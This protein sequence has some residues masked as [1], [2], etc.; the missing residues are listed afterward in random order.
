MAHKDYPVPAS[1]GNG[2]SAPVRPVT[3]NPEAI[4]EAIIARAEGHSHDEQLNVARALGPL[5]FARSETLA[6]LVR[7]S[8]PAARPRSSAPSSP[9][10]L[11]PDTLAFLSALLDRIAPKLV[12]EFG[13]GESTRVFASWVADHDSRLISI[14][15]DKGWVAEVEQQLTPQQRESVTVM[16]RPLQ[17]VR[18]GLRQF[19]S[20]RFLD[21]IAGDIG[22]AQLILIDGPHISGRE[23]VQYFAMA[24]ASPGAIIVVD[25]FRHYS[26][27]EILLGV[28]PALAACFAGEAIAENS[29]GL[30]VL[31]CLKRPPKAKIPALGVRP[32]LR[33]YWRSLRDIRT[34]GTGE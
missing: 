9:F 5:P 25:D 8:Y 34:Y 4:A 26:V 29:H 10:P 18:E 19:L 33:S 32:I 1:H 14:E 17:L 7:D 21:Q 28:P 22:K 13:S 15:H 11:L 2:A 27:R 12:V 30:F 6:A 20:Y 31:Q 23:M 24:N 16:H 3:V